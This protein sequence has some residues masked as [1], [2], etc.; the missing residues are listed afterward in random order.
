MVVPANNNPRNMITAGRR[1]KS[2]LFHATSRI[3]A[4]EGGGSTPVSPSQLSLLCQLSETAQGPPLLHSG[5][6]PA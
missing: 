1:G 6:G 2:E 4:A 3:E 5:K